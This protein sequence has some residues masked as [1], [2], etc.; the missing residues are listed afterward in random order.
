MLCLELLCDPSRVPV[1]EASTPSSYFRKSHQAS[2]DCEL[3]LRAFTKSPLRDLT[4]GGV[5]P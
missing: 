3:A 5:F 2:A 4:A 1:S